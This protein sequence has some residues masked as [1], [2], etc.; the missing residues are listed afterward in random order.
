[1]LAAVRQSLGFLTRRERIVY[2]VLVA[3]RALSGLLDVLGIVL[4]GVLGGIAAGGIDPSAPPVTVAGFELPKLDAGGVLSL[5][6]AVLVVFILKAAV[7]I[8]LSRALTSFVAKVEANKAVRIAE[9][10][11]SSTLGEVQ[12]Y[13]KAELQWAVT[14]STTFAFSRLLNNVSTL[15]TE[16]TLLLLVGV[17]LVIVDP[18]AAA[19]VT[20]YFAL[21]IVI[22]QLG[23]GN[24]LRRAG[25]ESADGAVKTNEALNDTLDSFREISVFSKSR[26]YL[27]RIR[28]ARTRVADANGIM[29]FLGGMPRYVVET[30]LILGVVIFIGVL[31]LNGQLVTGI[32]TIG[33]FLTGGVR[34]MASL[35]PLQAAVAEIKVNAEQALLA[36]GFLERAHRAGPAPAIPDDLAVPD[37]PL[38]VDIAGATFTY[39]GNDAV[40]LDDVS[41]HLE[42]GEQVAFVGPSGA[43]KTTLVDL[44]LGLIEPDSGTVLIGGLEPKIL[45]LARPGV[46]AYVPQKPGL[47]T[48]SIGENIALGVDPLEIDYDRVAEVVESAHLSEFIASLPEGIHTSVGKQ[49]NALSGGQVQRLGLARALY[50][51]PRLLILDEATSAL[52]AGSEATVSESLDQLRGEVTV[53]VIAHRLSTVQHA[54][55]VHVVEGGRL[56]ASGTFV[57]LRKSVP[58]IADY[59]KLMS[60][61]EA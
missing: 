15:I 25:Q 57:A 12:E 46:I 14:S 21:I 6:I 29:A 2:F 13:S 4:I 49:A 17:T 40:T 8:T 43:G 19:A 22:I 61:D 59:V 39:P 10:V 58:M 44:L 53:V 38:A 42:P 52:D 35:L 1:M 48:G 24:T 11:L 16:T 26:L 55:Q 56:T 32:V 36:R 50:P 7:A 9:H 54:D 23:I 41:I 28:T 5:A 3:L 33:V 20:I 27:E 45:R 30:A 34:I 37:G 18:V 47:V 31:F 51:R 60:F